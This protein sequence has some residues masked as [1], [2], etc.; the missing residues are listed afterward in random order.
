[1]LM[2]RASL[3]G[4]AI[5]AGAA[6]MVLP[7][8]A[9]A[10]GPDGHIVVTPGD[11]TGSFGGPSVGIG[12]TRPGAAGEPGHEAGL[13][14]PTGGSGS[15]SHPSPGIPCTY[16]I[17][18]GIEAYLKS[19]F[20]TT[21]AP[22]AAQP[23]PGQLAA[24]AYQLLVLPAP[25]PHFSPDLNTPAGSATVVGEHT[26]FWTDKDSWTNRSQRAQAGAVWAEVTATPTKLIVKPG[27]DR[28]ISCTGPGTAYTAAVGLHAAS[29]DCGYVPERPGDRSD[30][31][32]VIQWSV[33]WTGSTGSAPASGTLPPMTSRATTSFAVAEIQS[34]NAS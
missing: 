28:S 22:G 17:S 20:G 32:F 29:P 11:Q 26:W 13:D 34:L 23:T 2:R 15:V 24:Q 27:A 4:T 9:V 7:G 19:C 18:G 33:R 16:D 30:A 25:A 3:I 31:V 10:D 8:Y 21:E 1:M 12:V 5:L 14:A 6:T